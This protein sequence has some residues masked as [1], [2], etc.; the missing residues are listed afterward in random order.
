MSKEPLSSAEAKVRGYDRDVVAALELEEEGKQK[1]MALIQDIRV[2]FR[3]V[4]RPKIT[5]N[6]AKGY[7][8]EWVLSESRIQELSSQDLEQCWEDVT[9]E[10]IRFCQEYFCFS[11]DEG[12]RFYLPAFMCYHLI[13]FPHHGYD[14]AFQACDSGRSLGALNDAQMACVLRYV[15]LCRQYESL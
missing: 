5:L 2:A 10:S 9:H 4:P 3:G 12:W 1:A 11:D 15:E 14:A 7:D 13:E 6:V 8:D